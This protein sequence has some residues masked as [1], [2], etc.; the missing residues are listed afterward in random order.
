M[1]QG[2][3]KGMRVL[4]RF[5]GEWMKEHGNVW[6]QVKILFKEGEVL[7]KGFFLCLCLLLKPSQMPNLY[8]YCF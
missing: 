4:V 8:Y 2:N 6:K 5:G 1:S 7:F 3:Y